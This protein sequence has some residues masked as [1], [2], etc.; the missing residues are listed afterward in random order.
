MT[1][2]VGRVLAFAAGCVALPGLAGGCKEGPR[3][4]AQLSGKVTFKGQPVPDGFLNFMPDAT[5][6]NR[7]E[8]KGFPIKYGVYNTAEGPNPGVYPGENKVTVS[9][10]DG[11]AK[12]LY[13]QGEQV[14]NPFDIKVSVPEGVTTK[15]IEVPESAGRNVRVQPT[16]D[17]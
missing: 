2:T 15:D 16:A 9:G 8:V 5:A 6:G 10:F 1:K 4:T 17:P 11:K 14:F 7:G 13:P 12:K 3:K